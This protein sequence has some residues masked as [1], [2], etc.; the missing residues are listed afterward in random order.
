MTVFEWDSQELILYESL[1]MAPTGLCSL[2]FS[3]CYIRFNFDKKIPVR[4]ALLLGLSLFIFFFIA[5]FPWPFI[6]STIPY[7]HPKNETAYF[8]QSEA[9]A[10]LLQFNETGELVGCNIAYKWCETTP[11]INLPIFYI[12]TILVLGIGI[13]LFA[14][15]L[16]IIYSTVLGPI[17]QGVLQGLFSSSG[18]I[19]NIFGPIIVT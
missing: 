1:F 11:R 3:I 5:T 16:D 9:A 6:S 15:S 18:D 7:A 13:P 17:K 4:I 8:K 10:A 2:M 12:S 14:I 19:I